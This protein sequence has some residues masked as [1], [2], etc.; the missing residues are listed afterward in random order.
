M[1]SLSAVINNAVLKQED[2]KI[3]VVN[4]THK[5]K[6]IKQRNIKN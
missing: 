4:R 6:E 2:K 5:L 3:K 1:T